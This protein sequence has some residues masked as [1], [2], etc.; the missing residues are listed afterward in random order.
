MRMFLTAAALACLAGAP[1][2][3]AR[4][5][6]HATRILLPGDTLRADD[7]QAQDLSGP[8][9]RPELL[10]ADRAYVGQEVKRRIS[11]GAPLYQRDIGAPNL[12]HA[13]Q[14]VRVFWRQEG[15]QLELEGRALESGPAGAEVRIS[16]ARTGRTIRAFVVAEGTAEIRAVPGTP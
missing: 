10:G 7:A 1:F 11:A 14:P 5:V 16:N 13:S 15:I 6:W 2:V 9:D 12:V 4:E 3:E 8:R